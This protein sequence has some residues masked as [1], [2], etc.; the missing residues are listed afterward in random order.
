MDFLAGLLERHGWHVIGELAVL[1][2]A[3]V[4]TFFFVRALLRGRVQAVV[5]PACGRV[6]SRADPRCPRCGQPL[7]LG[8]ARDDVLKTRP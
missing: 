4:F 1:L 8:D 2:A 3:A 7:R 6:A 5:C